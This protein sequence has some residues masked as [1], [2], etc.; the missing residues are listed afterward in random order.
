MRYLL[1][2]AVF[3]YSTFASSQV[4]ELVNVDNVKNLPLG[5]GIKLELRLKIDDFQVD[6]T[7]CEFVSEPNLSSKFIVIPKDTGRHK[8]GPIASGTLVSNAIFIN[9][10]PVELDSEVYITMP[11]S[12]I[13]DDE[14][15]LTIMNNSKKEGYTIKDLKLKSSDNYAVIS[16]SFSMSIS[17][18]EGQQIKKETV[19]FV[20]KPLITGVILIDKNS[21]DSQGIK[22]F[23]L[24]ER[25]LKVLS[26]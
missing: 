16:D 8:I 6:R 2:C 9:V 5:H 19:T 7:K 13:V 15:K 17:S 3:L 11:D 4:L 25:S 10:V 14:V 12:S 21:F 20:I 26:K 18:K 22:E 1:V 24:K 23:T